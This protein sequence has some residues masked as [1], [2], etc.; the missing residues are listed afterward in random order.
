M[1][2]I[3]GGPQR[4]QEVVEALR[5]LT[6]RDFRFFGMGHLAYIR[7]VR[8]GGENRFAVC[9]ADGTPLTVVES[10]GEAR[11]ILAR[12]ALG[13]GSGMVH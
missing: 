8:V 4:K 11:D 7:P 13:G 1:L 2:T 3:T 9:G 5:G 12:N 10:A 6:D